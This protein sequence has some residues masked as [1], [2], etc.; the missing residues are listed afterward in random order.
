MKDQILLILDLD[1]T[2]IFASKERLSMDPD[3][4]L[5]PHFIYK[6]PYHDTFIR[7]V[8]GWFELAVWTS[9]TPNYAH[10]IINAFFPA[11]F[12]SFI[13]T[14][15]RCTPR[16]DKE[17]NERFWI[18]DLKKVKRRGYDL[19]RILIVDDYPQ[20]ASRNYGNYI[21]IRAYRGQ[22]DENDLQLLA[23]Y[24]MSFTDVEDVRPIEKRFWYSRYQT[25]DT[26][27]PVFVQE[28]PTQSLPSPVPS[29]RQLV[30]ISKYLSYVLRHK[31]ESIGLT[32]DANGWADINEL[33]HCAGQSRHR[34]TRDLLQYVVENNDK[35]RFAVSEDGLRIRAVQGHSKNVNLGLTPI[36][37]PDL[38]YHGTTQKHLK[39]IKQH[40]LLKGNRQYV[41]L[42]PDVKTATNVGRRHGKPVVLVINGKKMLEQNIPFILSENG[43]WLTDYVS[44]EYITLHE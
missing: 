10:P 11:G 22:K 8:A 31:P 2:L 6:R 44:P 26:P 13:W 39:S 23:D 41:H 29:E 25:E 40:G 27:T 9:S 34:L 14:R 12:F 15:E 24:L 28:V 19:S 3:L 32:L 43:I 4:V 21:P 42:S 5:P 20:T 35:K 7:S 38:L 36:K 18:K 17:T 16:I 37:P 30:S 33:I 1:E